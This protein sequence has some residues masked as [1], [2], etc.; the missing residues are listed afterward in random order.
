MADLTVTAAQVGAVFP[1]QARIRP[2]IAAAAITAGQSVYRNTSA[3]ADL[4]DANASGKHQFRGIALETVG[5][6]QSVSVLEDGECYGFDLSGLAYDALAYQSDTAG[7]LADAA[8]GTTTIV[9][10]RVAALTDGSTLTKVLYV[11]AKMNGDW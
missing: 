2:Y 8:S 11:A 3:K 10:G 7:A 4:C 9:A 6:G 1:Q 5:A